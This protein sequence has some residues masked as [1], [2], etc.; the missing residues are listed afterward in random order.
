MYTA[1]LMDGQ[2]LLGQDKGIIQKKVVS[3]KYGFDAQTTSRMYPLF[4]L[5]TNRQ[6]GSVFFCKELVIR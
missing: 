2:I 1:V 4:P 6:R 5:E 3:I